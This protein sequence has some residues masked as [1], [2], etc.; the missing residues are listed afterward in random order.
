MDQLSFFF[1]ATRGKGG[2]VDE[3][4]DHE[5]DKRVEKLECPSL[6]QISTWRG[7]TSA[8]S[9]NRKVRMRS[10]QKVLAEWRELQRAWEEDERDLMLG[11][12]L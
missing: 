4:R 1:S 7:N 10:A 12:P 11:G 8:R 2:A 9:P 3:P 5:G 6:K